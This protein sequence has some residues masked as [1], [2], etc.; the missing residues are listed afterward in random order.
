[1]PRRGGTRR[2]RC[3]GNPVRDAGLSRTGLVLPHRDRV[4]SV[5]MPQRHVALLRA[6]NLGKRNKV[7]M[8]GLRRV[9]EDAGCE[10]V[11]TYIASGNVVFEHAKPD[12][13]KLEAAIADAFG[14]ETT[15]VL[16]TARQLKS[17]VAAHPF[18][19]DTSSSYVAFLAAKPTA[20]KLRALD[21]LDL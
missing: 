13:A 3:G 11:Q 6:V 7:P 15:I 8:A 10:S 19:K 12:A 21:G 16:R 2:R 5:G 14:V 4:E 18:G 17:L 20:A 9:F 1:R